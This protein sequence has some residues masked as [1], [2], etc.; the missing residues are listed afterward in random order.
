MVARSHIGDTFPDRFHHTGNLMSEY[1]GKVDAQMP[2]HEMQVGVAQA[3]RGNT[4]KHF[5][6]LRQIDGDVL[7]LKVSGSGMENGRAHGHDFRWLEV[8][9]FSGRTRGAPE[10]RNG[11]RNRPRQNSRQF[12]ECRG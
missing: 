6:R 1:G 10:G 4:H 5:V 8:R 3:G 11:M 9:V 12:L 7:D 2:F